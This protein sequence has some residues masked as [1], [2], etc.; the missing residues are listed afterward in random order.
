[1]RDSTATLISQVEIIGDFVVSLA[2]IDLL[3]QTFPLKIN[4]MRD[5]LKSKN[6]IIA[7]FDH[8]KQQQPGSIKFQDKDKMLT[9]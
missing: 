5:V 6:N 9:P 1:M 3:L 4:I 2:N 7:L 8:P